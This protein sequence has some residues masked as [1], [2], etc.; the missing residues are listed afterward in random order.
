MEI[1]MVDGDD[2][3]NDVRL[4]Y[5]KLG[6]YDE[7]FSIQ[8]GPVNKRVVWMG[9]QRNTNT[10]ITTCQSIGST[11]D[12]KDNNDY[13]NNNHPLKSYNTR[14][15]NQ[16]TPLHHKWRSK[17]YIP[18]YLGVHKYS[19]VYRYTGIYG[20]PGVL[21]YHLSHIEGPVERK[22]VLM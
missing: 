2:V 8:H 1:R 10:L 11:S 12:D 9:I 15:M 17:I 22:W 5:H 14:T 13:E 18:G 16:S 3:N 21:G 7:H 6:D 4:K 19:C 20:Y